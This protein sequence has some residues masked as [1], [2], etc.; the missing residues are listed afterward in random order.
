MSYRLF[1]TIITTILL[2]SATAMAGDFSFKCAKCH[3]SPKDILP[4]KHIN[5][6]K[7]DGCFACHQDD[8]KGKLSN[9]VHGIHIPDM[10]TTVDTCNSCHTEIEPRLINV[11]PVNEYAADT[12]PASKAFTS[13][14]HEGTLANSHKNSGL[15]CGDCHT[16]YDYDELDNMAKKCVECHGDYPEV[17]KR[18]ADAGYETNPHKSHFP[19][20]A[21]TKCHSMH[22]EFTDFCSAKCHKWGFNWKQKI[23]K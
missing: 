1:F 5:K 17:A 2:L 23:K 9:K 13:Y 14:Y 4:A 10:G 20:L 15:N 18:T 8:K 11:D 19:T 12:E 22:G 7:F 21:C 3:D 6:D 16:T